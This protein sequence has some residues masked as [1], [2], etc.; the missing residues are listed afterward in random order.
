MA[1]T[2][3]MPPDLSLTAA[4]ISRPAATSQVRKQTLKF[5]TQGTAPMHTTP[6]AGL[7]SRGPKSGESSGGKPSSRFPFQL[8]A[9]RFPVT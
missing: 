9:L 4:A 5:V 6:Q 2:P 3:G 8:P 7:I 1:C